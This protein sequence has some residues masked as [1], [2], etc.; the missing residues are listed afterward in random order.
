MQLAYDGTAYA[1]WA[2]QPGLPTVQGVVED[3][4]ATVLRLT[5][6]HPVVCAGRTDAGVHA[7]GQVIH[8]DLPEP[9]LRGLAGRRRTGDLVPE[10][11]GDADLALPVLRRRLDALLPPDVAVRGVD[12]APTGFDAR[13]SASSR[14]Y[15]YRVGDDPA[16]R[17]PLARSWVLAYPR[18]LDPSAMQQAATALLG[19]HDFAAFCR[20]RPGASTV[21]ALLALS[22][23]RDAAGLVAI[24]VEADA[25]CHSMVR[26]LV[27]ALLAVGDGRRPVSWPAAVLAAGVRDPAVTVVPAHGLVLEEVRYPPDDALAARQQVTRAVRSTAGNVLPRPRPPA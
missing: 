15:V 14:R 16:G 10:P 21:R 6:P 1:G 22:C 7:R 25:F 2:A 5:L 4:L 8:V 27:G 19:E 18:R 17:D 24:E 26:A 3:A 20:R 11:T 13:F 9:A 12:L 23:R